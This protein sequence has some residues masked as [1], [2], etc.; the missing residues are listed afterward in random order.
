MEQIGERQNAVQELIDDPS[1]RAG[2]ADCLARLCDLERLGVR[3]ASASISPRDLWA[4]AQSLA[5]LP[6]LARYLSG[7]GSRFLRALSSVDAGLTEITTRID[8]AISADAT[9]EITEGGIFKSGY[10]AELDEVRALLSGG[11]Q[12]IEDYQKK[13]QERTQIRSLKVN[14]NSTFGYYIEVTH[15]NKTAV[16]DDYIRKQTLTNAE[17]YITPELKEYEAKV[18]NAEKSQGDLEYKLYV[19]FRNQLVPFGAMVREAAPAPRLSRRAPVT[20]DGGGGEPVCAKT[21][22]R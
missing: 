10:T 6:E 11:K 22:R 14:F 16:P 3:V 7:T 19:E 8:A 18:L 13:E 21:D 4:I 5:V 17:R 2:I 1:R 15:A 9:R 12:W 20:V